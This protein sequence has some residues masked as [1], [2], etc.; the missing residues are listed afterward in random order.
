MKKD[1]TTFTRYFFLLLF[2]FIFWLILIH[3]VS[4]SPDFANFFGTKD[5][6]LSIVKNI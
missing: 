4:K 1:V 6:T 2:V 5:N 3:H